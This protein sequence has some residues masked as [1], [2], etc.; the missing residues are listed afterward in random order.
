MDRT[1]TL[2]RGKGRDLTQSFDKINET[3]PT[4]HLK[5]QNY[6]TKVQPKSSITQRLPTDVRCLTWHV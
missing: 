1:N 5:K 4:E 3:I 6:N 2:V